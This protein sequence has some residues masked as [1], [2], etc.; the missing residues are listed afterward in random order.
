MKI[1]LVGLGGIGQRHARNLRALLGTTVDLIAYRARG[2][3][4]VVTPQLG[5]DK[6]KSVLEEFGIRP[7]DNLQS[8]L[9]ESPDI[10]FVCNPS[11]MH[12]DTALKCAEAGCDLFIEKPLSNSVRDVDRLLD[13]ISAKHL[14]AMVGYQLRFHPCVKRLRAIITTGTIGRVLA[15]NAVIGEFMPYWHRYEDYRMM[16]A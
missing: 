7:F 10:A 11:S 12:V 9:G 13:I 8:A 4:G 6:N 14:V 16:Y 2:L 15:V 1:L 5:L 3:S